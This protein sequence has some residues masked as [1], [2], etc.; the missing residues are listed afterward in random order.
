MTIDGV[1][2]TAT[3]KETLTAGRVGLKCAFEFAGGDWGALFKT[4][5]FQGVETVDVALVGNECTVPWEALATEGTQLKIGVYGANGDG[6]IVIPTVWANFGRIQPSAYPSGNDPATPSQNANAYA[7]ETAEQALAVAQSV[8]TD[9][10]NGV[11]NGADGPGVAAGGTT[12]QWLKKASSTDYDTTWDDLPTT[13]DLPSGGTSGQILAKASGT[14]YDVTWVDDSDSSDLYWC[15]Y[16]ST[17]YAEVMQAVNDGL[18]PV[19][20]VSNMVYVLGSHSS[21]EAR[22]YSTHHGSSG[23]KLYVRV[24][25][26]SDKWSAA[27]YVLGDYS[28]PAGGTAGQVLKKTADGTEW[29]NESGGGGTPY[30]SNPAA[31]GTASPGSSDNYS[32]GD[33][34]HPKPSASD[35]GAQA[36]ITA[37]GI[38]KGDGNGGVSAATAGTDY[39]VTAPVSSVNGQT[40]AV[41]LSIPSSASDVGAIPAPGS[42]SSSDVLTY[43]G[44]AWAASAPHYVPAGGNAGA[45]LAKSSA[46]DYQVYWR[47]ISDFT[48]AGIITTANVTAAKVCQFSFWDDTHYPQ[49]LFITLASANTAASALTLKVNGKGPYPIYIN[50]AASSATNYTLP[51]G[52]YIVLFDGTNFYFDTTGKIPGDITGHASGDISAPASPTTGDFLCWNGSA[53]AATS[54]S[55]WQGG[56]Y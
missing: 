26:S 52:S 24:V 53:W 23:N 42:P 14:D 19:M 1:Q 20:K 35:I 34:V 33:H 3:E 38:L 12:G 55:A 32:R 54:M 29:A 8:R 9:A 43:S 37:S 27:N 22:F 10:D 39:L 11:F 48:P 17:S 7:V 15:T 51:A 6:D 16:F 5:V 49:Y 2:A 46:S 41:S 30:T 18:L 21:G 28:L 47:T 31:L 50:G 56:N 13:H 40:G 44:S 4:A 25:D 45:V 36:K